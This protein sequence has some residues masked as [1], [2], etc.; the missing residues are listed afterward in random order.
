MS[1]MLAHVEE[2]VRVFPIEGADRIEGIQ[3]LG[4]ECVAKKDEFKVGDRCV[5]IEI[6]SIVP[7]T[8]MFEFLRDRKF[9]VKTIKLKKQISQG[10]AIPLTEDLKDKPIGYDVTELLQIEKYLRPEEREEEEDTTPLPKSGMGTIAKFL[11]RWAW[12]RWLYSVVFPKPSKGFPKWLPKTDEERIQNRP[13]YFIALEG[14]KYATEKIDGQSHTSVIERRRGLLR[15]HEFVVCSRNNR[16]GIGSKG[17]WRWVAEHEHHESKMLD[18]LED[19]PE[20]VRGIAIQGE[21]IGPGIQKNRYKREEYEF[22][23]FNI[24]FK[25]GDQAVP[26]GFD[27]MIRLCNKYGFKH[28]PILEKNFEMKPTLADMLKYAD[29]DSVLYKTPREGVVIRTH[30]QVHSFKVVSNK[31]LLKGGEDE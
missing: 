15:K 26:V 28:V 27:E 30:D 12:F 29:G 3:V 22:Y 1:R 21:N 5:Y 17:S 25:I 8:P 16:M 14:P 31:F 11:Y 18:M 19:M 4:W 2:V 10:L 13:D 23:V 24:K 7:E 6:D 9:R 20:S